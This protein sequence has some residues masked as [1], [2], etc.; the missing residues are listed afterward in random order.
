MFHENWVRKESI[1]PSRSLLILSLFV[2]T[3]LMCTLPARILNP[4]QP[5]AAAP[6]GT[7]TGEDFREGDQG[8]ETQMVGVETK[9]AGEIA[10]L[11]QEAQP[12]LAPTDAPT[13]TATEIP[14]V[15]IAGAGSIS[16][17]LLYPA[18]G[19]PPLL[20]VAYRLDIPQV[21][22]IKTVQ[23]QNSYTIKNLPVGTY[24]VVAYQIA[25]D[26]AGGYSAA[27]ACGLSSKCTDHTL[28]G[29][30]VSAG[31]DTPDITPGDWYAPDGAFPP[32]PDIP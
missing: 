26:M 18:E 28:L 29:V 10:A 19:I 17:K 1:M 24:N 12:L 4:S 8:F 2:L 11:T 23:G 22:S 6:V 27:V 14:S 9:V 7:P 31:A 5:T 21:F 25:G 3:S 32:K 30:V 13:A 20:I 16:G 15:D